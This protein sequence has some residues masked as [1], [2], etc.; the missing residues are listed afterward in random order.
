MK[1]KGWKRLFRT[2][3]KDNNAITIECFSEMTHT[4]TVLAFVCNL[5]SFIEAVH[6]C[7]VHSTLLEQLVDWLIVDTSF[8]QSEEFV[9]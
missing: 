6:L 1:L 3:V 5:L 7:V 9:A 2:D 4:L 8:T